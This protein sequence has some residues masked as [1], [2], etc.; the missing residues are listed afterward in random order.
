MSGT[1]R[2]HEG[3]GNAS[4]VQDLSEK[5]EWEETTYMYNPI[6]II[7]IIIISIIIIIIIIN[8]LLNRFSILLH[9][10]LV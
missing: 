10:A 7:I 9:S 8:W 3:M 1:R 4:G 2:N 6:I 5:I